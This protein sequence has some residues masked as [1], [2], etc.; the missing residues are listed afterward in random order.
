[1][2]QGVQY[3]TE[4]PLAGSSLL[5]GTIKTPTQ[6]QN[7]KL[8]VVNKLFVNPANDDERF[9][10]KLVVPAQV[11]ALS[12]GVNPSVVIAQAY[13][14]SQHGQSVLAAKYQNYFGIK[15]NGTGQKVNMPT[16]EET[17]DGS[18]Y[19]INADFQVYDNL[20]DS[21]AAN[22]ALLRNGISGQPQRYAGSWTENTQSYRDETKNLTQNYAT[23][24]EYGTILNKFIETYG[25]YVLDAHPV[26]NPDLIKSVK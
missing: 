13:V 1:M 6:Y 14:E 3:V 12:Y 11:A 25:L 26:H 15:Y 22:T 21:M 8:R 17:S 18:V 10:N 2:P 19:R 23:A 4:S 9:I 20:E 7:G 24:T 16:N 5:K